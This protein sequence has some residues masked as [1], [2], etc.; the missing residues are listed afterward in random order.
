[1]RMKKCI[2]FQEAKTDT[3]RILCKFTVSRTQ[4]REDNTEVNDLNLFQVVKKK[5]KVSRHHALR[6]AT[7]VT[8]GKRRQSSQMWALNC[9]ISGKKQTIKA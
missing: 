2:L 5:K 8:D 3:K 1:M 7:G 9:N 4:K 6:R